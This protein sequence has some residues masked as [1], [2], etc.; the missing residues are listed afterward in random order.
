MAGPSAATG[1]TAM[2]VFIVLA[3]FTFIGITLLASADTHNPYERIDPSLWHLM[4]H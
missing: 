3:A 1:I 4:H 2:T